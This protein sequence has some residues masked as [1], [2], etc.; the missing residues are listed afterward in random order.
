MNNSTQFISCLTC[1]QE[2]VINLLK[3]TAHWIIVETVSCI[4]FSD[5]IFCFV[6]ERKESNYE[7]KRVVKTGE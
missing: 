7:I 6:P 4:P 2:Y 3:T 5:R 1:F